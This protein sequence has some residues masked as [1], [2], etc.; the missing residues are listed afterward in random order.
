MEFKGKYKN[1]YDRLIKAK[2]KEGL[3]KIRIE[4]FIEADK[5]EFWDER[6]LKLIEN[7]LEPNEALKKIEVIRK[8]TAG[9]DRWEA[10]IKGIEET[11]KIELDYLDKAIP[12]EELEDGAWYKCDEKAENFTR[13]V[14]LAQWD[15]E[16]QMF[17]A[18][19]QQQ[20]GMDGWLDHWAD[21]IDAGCA[22]FIPLEKTEED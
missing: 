15:E 18:P 7:G 9:D 8:A 3:A 17:R 20:F 11:R 21:A 16:R 13:Y 6:M 22:G 4:K 1:W 10:M 19:G 2:Y 12:K 5:N 14:N